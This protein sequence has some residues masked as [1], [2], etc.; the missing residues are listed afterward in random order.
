MS[1]MRPPHLLYRKKKYTHLPKAEFMEQIFTLGNTPRELLEDEEMR[2]LFYEI[3]FADMKLVE[4][5]QYDPANEPLDIPISVFA[6]TEDGRAPAE[7][8]QEWE[9]YTNMTFSLETFTGN[10]FFAFQ[11]SA[12][13]AVCTA[14]KRRMEQC[15]GIS[16]G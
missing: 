16:A 1:A 2:D 15:N 4:S 12:M 9:R 8:L 14:I 11:E 7:D 13:E 6:G 3:L 5:Y 10:H